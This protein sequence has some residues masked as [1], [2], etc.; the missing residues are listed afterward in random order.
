M[1][2]GGLSA[3]AEPQGQH[4][5]QSSSRYLATFL[6]ILARRADAGQKVNSGI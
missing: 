6:F 3:V 1:C 2:V 4:Q 5:Q